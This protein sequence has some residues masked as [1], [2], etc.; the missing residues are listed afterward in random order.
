M[1]N[2][3]AS[4]LQSQLKSFIKVSRWDKFEILTKL[5]QHFIFFS[6]FFLLISFNLLSKSLLLYYPAVII[7]Y[8]AVIILSS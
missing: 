1:S 2:I 8:P 4:K 5:L 7:F 3:N 6:D